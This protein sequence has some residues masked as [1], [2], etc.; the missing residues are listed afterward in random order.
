MG[1]G[2]AIFANTAGYW[3]KR[4]STWP[5][6]A[7]N[8]NLTTDQYDSDTE[9]TDFGTAIPEIDPIDGS[10]TRVRVLKPN[11]TSYVSLTS[12]LSTGLTDVRTLLVTAGSSTGS[13]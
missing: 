10:T 3:P 9:D 11:E 5:A 2:N 7:N 4:L 12:T 6:Y 1:T 13:P 8:F